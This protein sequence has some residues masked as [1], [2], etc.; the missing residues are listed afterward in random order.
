MFIRILHSNPSCYEIKSICG[1]LLKKYSEINNTKCTNNIAHLPN[2]SL[3]FDITFPTLRHITHSLKREILMV[4]YKLS[5]PENSAAL[6]RS[7][8]SLMLQPYLL[9]K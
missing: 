3:T 7:D 5:I 4:L 9:D 6:Y 1:T 2:V 8:A